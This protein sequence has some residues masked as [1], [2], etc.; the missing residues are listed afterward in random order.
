[1]DFDIQRWKL[2]KYGMLKIESRFNVEVETYSKLK[3]KKQW[4][5]G[6]RVWKEGPD[7]KT[8]S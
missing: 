3:T 5:T 8:W 4:N 1:M 2:D 7:I 6:E